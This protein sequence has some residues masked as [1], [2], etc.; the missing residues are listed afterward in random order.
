[1]IDRGCRRQGIGCGQGDDV[2]FRVGVGITAGGDDDADGVAG[3]DRKRADAGEAAAGGGPKQCEQIGGEARQNHLGLGVAEAGV[4]FDHARAGGCEHD[5]DEE[6]A[7]KRDAL[8]GDGVHGRADDFLID[9]RE[10]LRRDDLG[11]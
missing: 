10:E 2:A 1:M 5:A 8:G 3:F 6:R 9:A 7:A 4:V 11:G